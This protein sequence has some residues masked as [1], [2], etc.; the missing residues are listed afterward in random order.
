[1]RAI[2]SSSSRPDELKVYC[3]AEAAVEI[4][5]LAMLHCPAAV[6][7]IEDAINAARN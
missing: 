7:G 5:T 2:Q 6:P 3:D 1:M 4:K